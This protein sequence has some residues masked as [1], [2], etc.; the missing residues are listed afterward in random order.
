MVGVVETFRRAVLQGLPPNFESL[1]A[2]AA[3]SAI[4]LPAAFAFFKYREATLADVI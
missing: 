2:A 4:V 1:A 3:I